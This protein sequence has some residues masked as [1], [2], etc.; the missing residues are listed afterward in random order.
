MTFETGTG[1]QQQEARPIPRGHYI[2]TIRA[3]QGQETLFLSYE[4]IASPSRQDIRVAP[5][6]SALR[7]KHSPPRQQTDKQAAMYALRVHIKRAGDAARRLTEA[8]SEADVIALN[9]AGSDLEMELQKL[10]EH[11]AAREEE[12]S[13]ILNFLQIAL[14]KEQFETF[15]T[16][17]C[18]VV[19]A[20]VG[21]FLSGRLVDE[22]DVGRVK[23]TLQSV[24]LDPW[25]ALSAATDD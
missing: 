6:S 9:S 13:E 4:P 25:K 2:E 16:E 15:D 3:T 14:K 1:E 5:S 10:W 17:T 23:L 18:K 19:E 21:D 8:A 7:P 11:R 12:W 24:G 22:E 20:V